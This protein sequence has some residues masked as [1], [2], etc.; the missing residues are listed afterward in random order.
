MGCLAALAAVAPQAIVQQ[1][2]VPWATL[3]LLIGA[4]ALG[5]A[6]AAWVASRVVLRAALL[7]ALRGE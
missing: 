3:A 5:G 7:P 4:V 6:L 2:G 1:A